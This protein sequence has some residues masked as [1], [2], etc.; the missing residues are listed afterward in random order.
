MA[1]ILITGAS[2]GFGRLTADTL[3]AAGHT[4]IASMRDPE[5]RNATA[6]AE[7]KQ[8]GAEIVALDVTDDAS[9]AAAVEA[10]GE[11]DVL[12]NNAGIGVLG[13][14]ET[15]TPSDW[16]KVFDVNVFGVQRVTQA[17]LP[18]MR[19]R[20]SGLVIFV[21][22]LLGR[23]VLPFLGPYNA[24]KW[25]LEAMAENYRVELGAFGVDCAIVEPGAYGT[26]FGE[27][28]LS[29]SK[30][31]TALGYGD[32]AGAPAAMMQG[33]EGTLAQHPKQSP[34]MVADV[35]LGLV[36]AEAG[37]RPFR[38]LVDTLGMGDG[39]KAYNEGLEQVMQGIYGSF[40]MAD[41]LKR[42]TGPQL[43]N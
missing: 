2:R 29:P 22:S 24:T 10:C 3:M 1:R 42:N 43:A 19:Q 26:D 21:S 20:G 37:Q 11:V 25:A 35:V 8:A 17:F 4:V 30:D 39:L 34:Q 5:G 14:Q 23:M 6:A 41:M 13:I 31:A 12:V 18:Q 16:Q 38:T 36:T 33:F 40:E 15:F 9:V 7:L 32:M 27:A 28:L